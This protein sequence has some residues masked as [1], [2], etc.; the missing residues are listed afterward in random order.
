MIAIGKSLRHAMITVD[1][2][3][4][5]PTNPLDDWWEHSYWYFWLHHDGAVYD[6]FVECIPGSKQFQNYWRVTITR[7][8]GCLSAMFGYRN[9]AFEISDSLRAELERAIR[10]SASITKMQWMSI[11]ESELYFGP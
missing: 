1:L 9:R 2:M 11:S 4:D 6:L 10:D 3:E 7:R 5:V 8:V